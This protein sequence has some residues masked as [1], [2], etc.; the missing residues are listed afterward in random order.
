MSDTISG[1][2]PF[3]SDSGR[4]VNHARYVLCA[5]GAMVAVVTLD[6]NVPLGVAVGALYVVPVLLTLPTQNRRIVWT[7]AILA[8]VL[9]L[10]KVFLYPWG[11]VELAIIIANRAISITLIVATAYLGQEFLRNRRK[12]EHLGQ[13]LTVCAWTRQIKVNNDWLP[14]EEYLEKHVG[15]HLTHGIHPGSADRLLQGND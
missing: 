12:I 7:F 10:G 8:L 14:M 1:I 4:E 13:L 11:N 5:I 3:S 6:L 15:L 9:T 2:A